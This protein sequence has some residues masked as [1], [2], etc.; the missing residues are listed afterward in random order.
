MPLDK[1]HI[2]FCVHYGISGFKE[3][4]PE[5]DYIRS[6]MR[7][8]RYF[9]YYEWYKSY[10]C[11]L[12]P[13]PSS[14]YFFV[15]RQNDSPVAIFP[16]KSAARSLVHGLSFHVLESSMTNEIAFTDFICVD[17]YD[18]LPILSLLT[19]YLKKSKKP[20]WDYIFF[21]NVLEDSSVI[22]YLESFRFP[23]VNSELH[24]KSN[25][26]FLPHTYDEYLDRL[27]KKHKKNLKRVW[28]KL[29]N[30]KD[31]RFSIVSD[32]ADLHKA[33]GEF[34]EV[35][36]SGWKGETGTKSAIKLHPKKV[37][38]YR[39]LIQHS[40]S[41]FKCQIA[42]LHVGEICIA[43]QFCICIRDTTYLHKCAYD[44]NYSKISPGKLLIEYTIRKCIQENSINY[45][46]FITAWEWHKLWSPDSY[47][48]YN[49]FIFNKSIGGLLGYFSKKYKYFARIL[50][51]LNKYCD[52]SLR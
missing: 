6:H 3:I 43:A 48:I 18:K 42:T 24:Y 16:L 35:E 30:N 46:N 34:L 40:S 8:P 31:V 7:K 25:Y 41:A 47:G 13:D 29:S 9:H 26:I 52:F 50:Y 38:Y 22:R 17:N 15:L 19:N 14:L 5:W 23:L 10:L 21:P 33:F 20:Q 2:S 28:K 32:K 44:E 45:L 51:Y 4:Q 1:S 36:A 27:S 39:S 12:E 37:N 49:V 11:N